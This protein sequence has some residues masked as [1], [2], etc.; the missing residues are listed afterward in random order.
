M[1]TFAGGFVADPGATYYLEAVKGLGANL[2]G[3]AA[4]RVRTLVRY[5]NGWTSI[6]NAEPNAGIVVNPSTTALAI[7]TA[8]VNGVPNAFAFESL[9][10]RQIGRASCRERV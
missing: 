2:P 7:G 3:A 6:S 5:T 10:G 1:L 8:L 4:L 9:I